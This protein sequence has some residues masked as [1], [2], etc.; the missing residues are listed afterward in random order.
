MISVRRWQSDSM[1]Y[2]PTQG[3]DGAWRGSSS[4]WPAH[5]WPPRAGIKR[6]MT[7]R[8]YTMHLDAAFTGAIRSG[9][10]HPVVNPKIAV[11]M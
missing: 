4:Q 11:S 3:G 8:R 5:L 7:Q 2:L 9:A 10:G 6:A 1:G